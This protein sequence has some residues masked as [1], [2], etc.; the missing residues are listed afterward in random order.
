MNWIGG[1]DMNKRHVSDARYAWKQQT[2]RQRAEFALWLAE[3]GLAEALYDIGFRGRDGFVGEVSL[4]LPDTLPFSQADQRE[5]S[6]RLRMRIAGEVLN[7]RPRPVLTKK[8]VSIPEEYLAQGF[9][10]LPWRDEGGE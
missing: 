7:E 9:R 1:A 3:H 8:V 4:Y 10:P 5:E 2:P 6:E